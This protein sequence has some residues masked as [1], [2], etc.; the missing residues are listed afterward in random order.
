MKTLIVDTT[1][2]HLYCILDVD[3]E[4]FNANIL[5]CKNRHS[6]LLA[7][8]IKD[9][10]RD[11]NLTFADLDCYAVGVGPGSFTGIRIGVSTVKGLS[12]AVSKNFIA[13]NNLL[14]T[15]YRRGSSAVIDAGNGWYYQEFCGISA[16]MQ[17]QLLPYDDERIADAVHF[18]AEKDYTDDL[19]ALVREMYAAEQFSA[20]LTPCYIRK[21]QAEVN[22]GR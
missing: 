7:T 8:A 17:P 4:V 18:D 19:V 22:S 21:S 16:K 1:T 10:L 6:E 12:V 11:A 3:G 9:V 20:T 5:R 13:I 2:Q 15:S 14:L